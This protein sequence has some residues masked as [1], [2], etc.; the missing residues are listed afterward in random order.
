MTYTLIRPLR[1]WTPSASSRA[2]YVITQAFKCGE[3]DPSVEIYCYIPDRFPSVSSNKVLKLERSVYGLKQAPAAFKDKLTSFFK[4][5]TFKAVN[6]SGTVWNLWMLTQG[7]SVLITACH[8]DDV[9]HFTNDQKLYRVFRRSFEKQ[10]DVKSSDIVD[11]FLGNEVIIDKSKRKVAIS[12]SHYILPFHFRVS[13]S[14]T[15]SVK[16][17][18]RVTAP[19]TARSFTR[20]CELSLEVLSIY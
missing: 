5:K 2:R 14:V 1:H 17:L 3:L 8:V 4:S 19:A 20:S 13:V 11:I 10:F 16:V 15:A 6:D 12:Q 7:S 18:V 9:L